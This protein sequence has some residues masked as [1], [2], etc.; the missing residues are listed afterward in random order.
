[1]PRMEL[2]LVG[3]TGLPNTETFGKID[4]YCT[5]MF[6]G[7]TWKTDECE[8]TTEPQW[9]KTFKF[10]IAD[11]NS[12]QAHICVWNKNTMSDDFL[13]DYWLSVS[14][15]DRGKADDR[16]VLLTKCKGNAELHLIV[17][18][19]DFGD[20]D[21]EAEPESSQ[22]TYQQRPPMEGFAPPPGAAINAPLSLIESS[23]T[24]TLLSISYA[25]FCLK[26]KKR[27]H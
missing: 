11:E 7:K 6:E 13:G 14:G 8:D 25:V 26:K 21:V 9:N 18:A 10:N 2:T 4:P 24:S 17:T 1:M 12:S 22:T 3:C 16:S 27:T 19:V 5:V 23:A 15:L 20:V